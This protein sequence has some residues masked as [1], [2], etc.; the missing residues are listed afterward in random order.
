MIKTKSIIQAFFII[1]IIAVLGLF[2]ILGWY[3]WTGVDGSKYQEPEKETEGVI[4]Q[5]SSQDNVNKFDNYEEYKDFLQSQERT[6]QFFGPGVM[7]GRGSAEMVTSDVAMPMTEAE[8][9]AKAEAP[10]GMGSGSVDYSK[11]NIQVEGVDEADIIKTD[12][13]YIYAL[14]R[15]NLF[16][17]DVYPATSSAVISEIEFESNPQDIFINKDRLVVY[18]ND[19][20]VFINENYSS[21]KRRNSY[22]FFK[23]FDLTDRENPQEVKD[24][25]FEGNFSDSRMIGDYI[26]LITSNYGYQFI[27]GEPIAP[28]ILEDGDVVSNTCAGEG[29]VMPDI[30]YFDI[31]SYSRNLT[32]ISAINIQNESESINSESYILAGNQNL[33]VSRNNIYITYTKYIDEYQLAMEISQEVVYP[34]LSPAEQEMIQKIE[35]VE[36]FVLSEYEKLSKINSIIDNYIQSLSPVEQESVYNKLDD[37]IRQKYKEIYPELEKTIIHRIAIAKGDI[38]YAVQGEVTGR[39]LNQ[40]SMDEKGEYFRIA[41]TKSR[42]WSQYLD[43]SQQESFNNLYVLNKDLSVIGK[44]EGLAPEERIYSVRFMQDR[45]YM[46][47]FEQIDPLFVIDLSDPQNPSVLGELKI[48]GYSNYLHPYNDELLI[49]IGKDTTID[50]NDRVRT[51]GIKLSLFDVT[52]VN[53][54]KEIDNYILGDAGSSSIALHDHKAFLFSQDKNLLAIPVVLRAS[55]EEGGYGELEFSGAAIFNIDEDGFEIK[56]RIDHSDGGESSEDYWFGGYRYYDNNVQRILYIEDALYTFSNKYLKINS[57]D[58]LMEINSLELLSE[59]DIE[60]KSPQPKPLID[61]L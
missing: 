44:I 28:R 30:Y 47:T 20:Q 54:P 27:E 29:C 22:T 10:A 39:V 55:D 37:A 58:D 17:I 8:E 9:M 2:L 51:Q 40:F 31:P 23:I 52:N 59:E 35:S 15:N 32:T 50:D 60:D 43:D 19:N 42:S 16:I 49:G 6:N 4:N 46:V 14:A 57:L 33:Y 1:L 41:T 26:Y 25:K 21:F 53:D 24:L 18:G 56:G 48:P 11:T 36:D 3:L 12:G 13:K 61:S 7:L 34:M 45:A 5:L 38:E